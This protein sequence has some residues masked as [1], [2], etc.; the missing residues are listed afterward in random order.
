MIRYSLLKLEDTQV[1]ISIFMTH[2]IVNMGQV[3]VWM[4]VSAGSWQ[5]GLFE[6]VFPPAEELNM[7]IQLSKTFNTR[8][9]IRE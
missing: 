6:F 5:E 7:F 4:W 1:N 3:Q 2:T 9:Y 8:N